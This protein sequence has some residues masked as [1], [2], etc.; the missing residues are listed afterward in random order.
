LTQKIPT[1]EDDR[2][3]QVKRDLSLFKENNL[4]LT[5]ECSTSVLND[6]LIK[7]QNL[8]EMAITLD[9]S[10]KVVNAIDRY[11]NDIQLSL[12]FETVFEN[13]Q[14]LLNSS[15]KNNYPSQSAM[16]L[17]QVEGMVRQLV[18][19]P[20]NDDRPRRIENLIAELRQESD[21]L[22]NTEKKLESNRIFAEFKSYNKS[23]IAD[24]ES[25]DSALKNGSSPSGAWQEQLIKIQQLVKSIQEIFP[26]INDSEVYNLA[27]KCLEQF[28]NMGLN[29]TIAQQKQYN[30]WAMSRI[31]DAMKEGDKHTGLIDDEA[32]LSKS[33]KK[34]FGPIDTRFL[35]HEVN[36]CY[37]EVF[38]HL[39]SH[40]DAPDDEEDFKK[41]GT[42]LN[43]L[44][45]MSDYPKKPLSDF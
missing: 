23:L 11:L 34:L 37:T 4:D 27:I 36:R 3:I 9:E 22:F 20:K 32:A 39:F 45:E 38:E 10:E 19:W 12:Q 26:K 21:R 31:K 25:Q 15:K 43:L 7:L 40:L 29:A 16:L 17:Q 14:M 5:D 41:E 1:V 13:A 44:K 30:S 33:M 28:N 8:K 35:T 42:K 2:D 18:S 6:K 24:V